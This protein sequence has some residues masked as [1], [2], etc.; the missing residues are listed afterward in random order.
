MF[1][2][3][4]EFLEGRVV[5]ACPNKPN[6]LEWPIEPARLMMAMVAA[7]YEGEREPGGEEALEWFESLVP[8][9]I[10]AP[11]IYDRNVVTY[12]VPVND[13]ADDPVVRSKQPRT[14]PSGFVGDAPLFYLYDTSIPEEFVSKLETIL[15]NVVRLG[16]SS[17]LV[18]CRLVFES[19][20]STMEPLSGEGV[21]ADMPVGNRARWN[22]RSNSDNT[23]QTSKS[24]RISNQGTLQRLKRD[25][26]EEGIER[27]AELSHAIWAASSKKEVGNLKKEL[28]TEFPNP[29]ANRRPAIGLSE[30]FTKTSQTASDGLGVQHTIFEPTILPLVKIEGN[31]LGLESTL[32]IT[33][34]LRGAILNQFDNDAPA[35]VCGHEADGSVT[36]SPHL[37]L[38]PLPHV[39]TKTAIDT[40]SSGS[41]RRTNRYREYADGH[42]LGAAIVL[43]RNLTSRDKASGLGRLLFDDNNEPKNIQLE[44]GEL[45]IWTLQR[46]SRSVPPVALTA[47][48]WSR[49]SRFWA[50]VTPVVLNRFP[51]TDSTQDFVGWQ[52]EVAGIVSKSCEHIGLSAPIAIRV[53]KH[54]PLVG[55]PSSRPDRSGFPLMP[56]SGGKPKGIQTHVVL[57]F[58]NEV[59]GPVIIGAGRFRGYGLCKPVEV[60]Q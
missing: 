50:S 46:E 18:R 6:K 60:S 7:H 52:N 10:D 20:L 43:P 13:R 2:I 31:A 25:Y 8:Y 59:Q 55:V 11:R 29:P 32:R 47:E 40:E 19:E 24:L 21:F 48:T 26:N 54:G 15:S 36:A 42:L 1:G 27:Y 22:L 49:P 41:S 3:S 53:L 12:Y 9:Q 57:E 45:G 4:V 14:F 16:H 51:K 38:L 39:G 30:R 58:A 35:W 5:A 23:T 56:S 37:A 17:S 28:K 33:A 44:L 34:A